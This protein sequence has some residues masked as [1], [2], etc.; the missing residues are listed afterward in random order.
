MGSVNPEII[1]S[2]LSTEEG[3]TFECKRALKKPADV[4]HTICAFAN[5]DGGTFVYGLEDPKKASGFDRLKGISEANDNCGELLKL[6]A[7]NFIPPLPNIVSRY[8][9]IVNTNKKSDQLLIIIVNPSKNVHSLHSGQTYI[10]RGSQN[11]ILTHEQAMQLHYEKGFTSFESE[12]ADISIDDIDKQNIEK[13]MYFNKSQDKNLLR[14]LVNNGLAKKKNGNILLNN[15]AAL[16]FT[17]NPFIALKR[18][19]GI[20]I[21]HFLGTH[22][23]PSANQISDD[24]HLPSRGHC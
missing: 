5:T 4:L 17:T 23:N 16:L 13:F 22:I 10:R 19:C 1:T 11:N 18:K 7:G 15:A 12:I 8:V 2:I 3:Q 14:F 24:L 21:S 6:I 20:T 9:E